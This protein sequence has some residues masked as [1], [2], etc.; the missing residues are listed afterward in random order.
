MFG[1]SFDEIASD[2]STTSTKAKK[3]KQARKSSSTTTSSTTST[4]PITSTSL[5]TEHLDAAAHLLKAGVACQLGQSEECENTA[6][7]AERVCSDLIALTTAVSGALHR[8]LTTK[9]DSATKNNPLVIKK[10]CEFYND[11]L[12]PQTRSLIRKTTPK[13][14]AFGLFL[15]SRMG[16]TLAPD[17]L[18]KGLI[19]RTPRGRLLA[20]GAWRH[21]GLAA[22]GRAGDLF[23]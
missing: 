2:P 18:Q 6:L 3:G 16:N 21:L 23:E 17:L 8:A 4:K 22:P 12:L 5:R 7:A 15:P 9:N 14:D 19:Q 20:E 1:G 11:D 10:W 13:L